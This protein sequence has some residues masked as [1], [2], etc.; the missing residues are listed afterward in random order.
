MWDPYAEFE[1]ATLPNGLTVHATHWPG[2]PWEAMGFLFH[3]GA[4][5]D[6]IG[7]EGLSHFDEHLVSKNARVSPSDL[8]LF[9]D[10]CG[11]RVKLGET[12]DQSTV[13]HFF[14]PADHKI[15]TDAFSIF[16]H[17]LLSAKLKRCIEHERRVVIEEFKWHYQTNLKLDLARRERRAVYA[18][19]WLE[20]FVRPLGHPESVGRM[21]QQDLQQHYD[22]HYTPANLSIVGV[23]GMRLLEL[24]HLLENSPFAVS[25]PGMRTPLPIPM[26]E[27]VQPTENRHVVEMSSYISMQINS[28][29][30]R[31]VARVP[32]IVTKR[33]MRIM[34]SML[35][36]ILDEEIRQRRGWTYATTT[37]C[38]FYRYFHQFTIHCDSFAPDAIT[39][40]EEIIETCIRSIASRRD[41]FDRV[42]RH[43]LVSNS[44]LDP[45]GIGVCD[46][47]LDDLEEEQ[48]IVT[49][50]EVQEDLE[51]VTFE[52]VLNAAQ[53]IVPER[54]WTLLIRP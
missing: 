22:A 39:D 37:G 52:D 49:L 23:G 42:K 38:I 14:V 31:S 53:W 50:T 33:T 3:S 24:V 17:M 8:Q 25:K 13:Y 6:P 20:R 34:R 1:S 4:E 11:G 18:G 15:L 47:A 27:V 10:D 29:A 41:L 26:T 40:I 32:G 44:L 36:E 48:R 51:R 45:T 46:D 2:R 35:R 12:R 9:F 16:G 5:Q 30:Y 54:R 28:C 7:L 21:T 43:A 19:C